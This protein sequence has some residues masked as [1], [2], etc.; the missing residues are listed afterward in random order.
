MKRYIYEK[1]T[2]QK[3]NKK[4]QI[5]KKYIKCQHK[6]LPFSLS[7][8]HVRWLLPSMINPVIIIRLTILSA[9]ETWWV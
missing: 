9:N 8:E 3:K 5:V 1:I 6:Y 4:Q 7:S 2:Q